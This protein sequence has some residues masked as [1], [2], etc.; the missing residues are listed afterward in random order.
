MYTTL[1]F[2][3]RETYISD[4]AVLM[5]ICGSD[6]FTPNNDT[7]TRSSGNTLKVVFSSDNLQEENGFKLSFVQIGI[8]SFWIPFFGIF[9]YNICEIGNQNY[10]Y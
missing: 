3:W 7:E 9:R 5:E 2:N 6:Q 10:C 8:C 1:F 4:D